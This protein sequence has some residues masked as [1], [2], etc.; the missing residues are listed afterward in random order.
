MSFSLP[1][2]FN[3]LEFIKTYNRSKIGK[4]APLD[5]MHL[6]I[7]FYNIRDYNSS[8]KETYTLNYLKFLKKITRYVGNYQS[9]NPTFG[10]SSTLPHFADIKNDYI[11]QV[12]LDKSILTVLNTMP[13]YL[14][15][16]LIL[17]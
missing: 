1:P 12:K 7:E 16:F 8:Q 13:K 17:K 6:N 5:G 4:T 11:P 10:L 14:K 2:L 15:R 9:I 3:T